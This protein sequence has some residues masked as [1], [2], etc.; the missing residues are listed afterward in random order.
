MIFFLKK[1]RE[2][3]ANFFIVMGFKKC[4]KKVPRHFAPPLQCLRVVV[5][6]IKI[7]ERKKF[8]G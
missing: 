8:E 7:E 2:I 1:N 6:K 5:I 4:L 3:G